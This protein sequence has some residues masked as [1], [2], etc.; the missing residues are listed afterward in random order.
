MEVFLTPVITSPLPCHFGNPVLFVFSSCFHL[1][2]LASLY[3]KSLF[4]LHIAD[5][6]TFLQE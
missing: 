5:V 6:T 1:L 3:F 2:N 4:E